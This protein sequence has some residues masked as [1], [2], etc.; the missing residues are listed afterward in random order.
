MA[1]VEPLPI[2]EV[3]PSRAALCG[4][5]S[6][7]HGGCVLA[8][9]LWNFTAT[10]TLS[11]SDN[12]FVYQ[13]L[14]ITADSL[15]HAI[16][17]ARR[18]GPGELSGLVKASLVVLGR[19]LES[20]QTKPSRQG[21]VTQIT[22]TIPRQRGLSGSS[23]VI[24]AFF[25]AMLRLH[26]LT[27][28]PT[29]TPSKLAHLVLSVETDEL[30]IKAGPQDRVVQWF[31]QPVLMDFSSRAYD[32]HDAEHGEYIIVPASTLPQMAL[33]TSNI[34]SHSGKLH[35]SIDAANPK[36][37]K[38]MA[39]AAGTAR[40]GA[41]ALEHAD[42]TALGRAMQRN[43]EIRVESFGDDLLGEANMQLL[44][45]SQK[46]N[47]PMNFTGSGGAAIVLLPE[48]TESL[49]MLKNVI[50]DKPFKGGFAVTSARFER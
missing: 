39:E 2:T 10:V 46:A 23:A 40:E 41:K 45:I 3:C 24:T 13:E 49:K 6:D 43:A 14:P 34:P 27:N 33:L 9:P 8:V 37:K 38:L 12:G 1:K 29:L 32:R 26:G 30:L 28:H 4:N 11:S 44:E 36:I 7:Q 42:L 50:A 31:C 16:D 17:K 47:C 19:I 20:T 15:S 18:E 5:P 22:T 21:F 25:K 35:G 48:G